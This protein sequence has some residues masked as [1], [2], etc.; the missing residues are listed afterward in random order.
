VIHDSSRKQNRHLWVRHG[1]EA[2]LARGVRCR[3]AERCRRASLDRILSLCRCS[4]LDT[5]GRRT[6][7]AGTR[8]RRACEHFRLEPGRAQG[9]PAKCWRTKKT[10]GTALNASA[11]MQCRFAATQLGSTADGGQFVSCA[12]KRAARLARSERG[13]TKPASRGRRQRTS[14]ARH[15]PE[16]RDQTHPILRSATHSTLTNIRQCS[17][18]RAASASP[19]RPAPAEPNCS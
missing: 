1:G 8:R 2:A 10:S 15:F 12:A 6:C 16:T 14:S 3:R 19:A 18:Q 5:R 13:A 7:S 9:T 17:K 4:L 11:T